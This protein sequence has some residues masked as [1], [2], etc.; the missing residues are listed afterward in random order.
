MQASRLSTIRPSWSSQ[1][2]Y[3]TAVRL[4]SLPGTGEQPAAPVYIDGERAMILR[5]PAIADEFRRIVDDYVES[6]Y[7]RR[8]LSIPL[9]SVPGRRWRPARSVRTPPTAALRGGSK[10]CP[11]RDRS[12]PIAG[13]SRS[14]IGVGG[15]TVPS[16]VVPAREPFIDISSGRHHR[17][18]TRRE[19]ACGRA[20]HRPREPSPSTPPGP[21]VHSSHDRNPS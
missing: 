6:R 14:G 9:R 10:R 15:R 21:G 3:V 5:G 8:G 1:R 19:Q 20:P 11:D 17:G 16:R 13:Q 18:R 4:C 12:L 2:A 7:P